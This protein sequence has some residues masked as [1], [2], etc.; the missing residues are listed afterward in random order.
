MKD[1]DQEVLQLFIR[2]LTT[3][4]TNAALYQ[5]EHLQVLHLCR[6][7]LEQAKILHAGHNSLVL[8]II[9]GRLIFANKPVPLNLAT[10]RLREALQYHDISHLQIESGVYSEELLGLIAALSKRGDRKTALTNSEHIHFGQVEVRFRDKRSVSRS[11]YS[12]LATIA[13]TE[14]DKFMELYDNVRHKQQLKVDGINEIVSGFINAFGSYSD[15]FLAIAP[16][17]S[18]DEYTYT[19]STNICL[20]NLAQARQLGIEGP[21]LNEIGIAAM[22]HDVG[23]MFIDPLILSKADKLTEEDWQIV[24]QHPRLGAEYLLATPGIPRLAV[25][26]AFEHHMRY[27]GAG[28]PKPARRWPQNL[29][30]YMTAISDTYDAMRTHRAY[31]GSRDFVQISEV[32]LGLAGNKLH[33]TLTRSFLDTLKQLETSR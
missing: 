30:S 25:V 26:T 2:H 22:L 14:Q 11:T 31:E 5:L 24:Q 7:A 21:L 4:A 20:L 15:A 27:D 17:R 3:A 33:P 19:H 8:K 10:E 12:E 28:Y 23:K 13:A 16:L 18:M 32:M 6:Q 29:S 1:N 9:E